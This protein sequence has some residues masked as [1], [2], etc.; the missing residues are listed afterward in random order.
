MYTY[1]GI[2]P[3]DVNG[4]IF[5]VVIYRTVQQASCVK[6]HSIANIV[7]DRQLNPKNGTAAGCR[8]T[9]V[10]E[11]DVISF[12]FISNKTHPYPFIISHK[13]LANI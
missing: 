11:S 5:C 4:K 7:K 9:K 3:I 2:S 6:M 1:L 12:Y 8:V 13:P 10:A